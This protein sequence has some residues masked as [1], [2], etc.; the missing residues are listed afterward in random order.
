ME[1]SMLTS[2]REIAADQYTLYKKIPIRFKVESLL[3]VAPIDSGLGGL[4]LIEEPLV[5]SFTRDY[6]SHGDDNPISWARDFDLSRW[7]VFLAFDE[8]ER[9]VGGAAVAIDS[10]V[11]PLDRLQRE[12]LAVLWDIRVHPEFKGQG[13]GGRLFLYAAE[14]ARDRGYGQLGIETDSSNVA[15][16]CF[17]QRMGCQLGA[18]HR[19]GYSGVPEVAQ[20]AMLL[21]YY[22]L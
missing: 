17:Y 12:D 22:D 18:I 8:A 20:Y 10:P 13:I 1:V 9:A 21:W 11:Y 16:C 4:R 19:F 6:D 14:W 3:R 2:I 5:E 15:A 7:G